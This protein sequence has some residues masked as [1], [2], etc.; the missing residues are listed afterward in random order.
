[1]KKICLSVIA[2]LV[3]CFV[4]LA[5]DPVYNRYGQ[6]I[7]ND[8]HQWKAKQYDALVKLNPMLDTIPGFNV[9]YT[10]VPDKIKAEDYD[11]CVTT[12]FIYKKYPTHELG[13]GVT[14][15]I[16]MPA[17]PMPYVVIIHGGG[18]MNGHFRQEHHIRAGNFIAGKGIAAI[19]IGYTLLAN[20]TIDNAVEDIG[21]ALAFIREHAVEWNI[22]PDRVGFMGNSAG[23]HLSTLTGLTYPATKAVVNINGPTDL[24]NFL[25]PTQ[26]AVAGKNSPFYY[27]YFVPSGSSP[28]RLKQF[29]PAYN[30]PSD[31]GQIPA[32]L[33]IHGTLDLTVP[34][35]QTTDFVELLRS[36]GAE[37]VEVNRVEHGSHS[38][39][40]PQM[41]S[42]E[43]DLLGIL[44]FLQENL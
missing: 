6:V 16:D 32:V 40:R 39:I 10:Y 11:K 30:I 38:L 1:M 41:A 25:G 24:S 36:K 19:R 43:D 22:D 15:P 42:Y 27:S 9:P 33:M 44:G 17:E 20:G 5:Q 28:E 21:D 7:V 35:W 31:P 4:G 12:D 14:L 37:T 8:G 34:Y 13:M 23:G 26:Q 2:L 29:S 3:F 18:W